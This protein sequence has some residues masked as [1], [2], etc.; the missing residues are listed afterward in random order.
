MC[1]GDPACNR[2]SD[3][4]DEVVEGGL[5][6]PGKDGILEVWCDPAPDSAVSPRRGSKELDATE[7]ITRTGASPFGYSGRPGAESRSAGLL[8]DVRPSGAAFEAQDDRQVH[9][10]VEREEHVAQIVGS[11]VSVLEQHQVVHH[12][13]Q[14][15]R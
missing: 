12:Q 1:V 5:R 13:T 11:T 8:R 14:L 9:T 2:V 10:L 4:G 6:D 7:T 3:S 15:R